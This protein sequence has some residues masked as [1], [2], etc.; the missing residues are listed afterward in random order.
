MTDTGVVAIARIPLARSTRRL[1]I[2]PILLFALAAASVAGGM[3]L[4]PAPGGWALAAAAALPILA[5]LY[6]VAVVFTVRLDVEVS[7]LRLR[8]LGSDRR[9]ALARGAVTRVPLTGERRAKLRPR[10]GAFG[11]GLG[12][13]RL[14]GD[15]TIQLV[16]LA[17]SAA[18][19]VVPTEAGRVAVAPRSEEQFLEAL[20]AAARVQQR[21]DQ[22]AARARA[23]PVAR[24]PEEIQEA[25]A[26]EPEQPARPLT[27]IER[28]LLEERLAAERAAALA[29]A[30][31][32]RIAAEQ[33]AT[34]AA[35]TAP[36]TG[37][38]EAAEPEAAARRRLP[39]PPRPRLA[40]PRPRMTAPALPGGRLASIALA[41]F[42]LAAAAG[43]WGTGQVAD[44][45]PISEA[46][47][48]QLSVA[49]TLAGPAASL[50]ALAARAWFPR[51]T[52]LV[53]VTSACALI[54][55][56]RSLFT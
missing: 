53:I 13:A 15:E 19:I 9:Y 40:L 49:L 22:V 24:L 1:L 16:R 55:V 31:R 33:A 34:L 35:G 50:A 36:G 7:T 30:E 4:L 39:R 2:V 26:P 46:R 20:A 11:W 14:R 18:V 56:V 44:A 5:A 10:L 21:L 43:I 41:A 6:L 17:R 27:G 37:G 32:E 12:T 42:P 38:E 47:A 29:A 48:D 25:P 52:G 54:L 23:I 45:F 8:W 3:L 28:T 51:L